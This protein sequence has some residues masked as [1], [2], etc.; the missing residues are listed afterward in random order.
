MADIMAARG[1]KVFL[2]KDFRGLDAGYDQVGRALKDFV[3]EG[4]LVKLGYGVYARAQISPLTNQ[5][6]PVASVQRL[7]KEALA[8][9][10]VEVGPTRFEREYNAGSTQVPTGQVIGVRKRVRRKLGYGNIKVSFE[11][12]A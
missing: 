12:V 9:L 4:R 2:R 6:A 1:D 11:R 5:P 10:K 8:K 3:R 7:A